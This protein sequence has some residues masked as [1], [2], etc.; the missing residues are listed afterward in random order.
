MFGLTMLLGGSFSSGAY[1]CTVPIR[2]ALLAA[3]VCAILPRLI[4]T[5]LHAAR[6][7]N[8]QTKVRIDL[9]DR[10]YE[11]VA[12]IDSGN[13]LTEP[14]TG[15]PVAVIRKG[16]LQEEGGIPIPCR[17]VEGEGLLFGIRPK[18]FW[19]L[20][21]GEWVQADVLVAESR[22]TIQSADVILGAQCLNAERWN[23]DDMDQ[24]T[25]GVAVQPDTLEENKG[26]LLYS[27]RGD[28]AATVSSGG[29]TGVD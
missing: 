3:A 29:G 14:L 27:H 20:V 7:K 22:M 6:T 16:L 13:L 26:D 4:L 19:V 1:I 10:S 21:K 2:I 17:T 18:G 9:K 28:A 15:K 12:L 11:L 8:M 24:K 5:F 23:A 25:A